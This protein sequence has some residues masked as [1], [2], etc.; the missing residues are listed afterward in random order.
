MVKKLKG[1]HKNF[2]VRT[3]RGFMDQS[4][5]RFGFKNLIQVIVGAT[6]LAIPIAF[7]E[8]TWRLGETLPTANIFLSILFI[9]L[10]AYRNYRR[11]GI[12]FLWDDFFVKVM[13]TYIFSFITVSIVMMLIQRAPFNTDLL[14]A[15]KRIVIVTFPAC[16]SAAIADTLR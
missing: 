15:V 6:L 5:P 16:M 4:N 9:S 8:E 14:L 3:Y 11:R 1:E 12:V 2:F 13:V 7:T 10:F